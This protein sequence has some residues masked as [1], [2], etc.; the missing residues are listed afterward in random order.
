MNPP[1]HLIPNALTIV[2]TSQIKGI[3]GLKYGSILGFH[4]QRGFRNWMIQWKIETKLM[5]KS[6]LPRE[7]W[8][9]NGWNW[10]LNIRMWR[11]GGKGVWGMWW[12][13]KE[14][15]VILRSG[16]GDGV[17]SKLVTASRS[18]FPLSLLFL[19]KTPWTWYNSFIMVT[20][21]NKQCLS[22]SRRGQMFC[23]SHRVW[24]DEE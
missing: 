21:H 7:D 4:N 5:N 10:S 2:I 20:N 3:M 17:T 16:R 14:W 15:V 13:W 19:Q 23:Y 18:I 11:L 12:K 9:R 22:T 6:H 24:C 1:Y 8:K